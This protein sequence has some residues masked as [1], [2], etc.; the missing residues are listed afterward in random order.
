MGT[1]TFQVIYKGTVMGETTI[2]VQTAIDIYIDSQTGNR[3]KEIKPNT[4]NYRIIHSMDYADVLEEFSG[5]INSG[6]AIKKLQEMSQKVTIDDTFI[7]TL[8][9]K[10]QNNSRLSEYQVYIVLQRNWIDPI[11]APAIVTAEEDT[12]TKLYEREDGEIMMNIIYYK[13]KDGNGYNISPNGHLVIGQ[14]HGHNKTQEHNMINI[15]GT[16]NRDK[17]TAIANGFNIYSLRA[18]ETNV[19]GQAGIDKVDGK[20][21]PS[22]LLGSTRGRP[23]EPDK[24]PTFDVGRDALDFWTKNVK[25]WVR[26][27]K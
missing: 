2:K 26:P 17:K 12:H 10:T 27:K 3:F 25:V 13:G 6:E 5:N 15:E 14:V 23:N 18:Y 1:N 4:E 24:R 9:Q 22:L 19:G 21:V 8:M 11:E 20:G 16:S 7:Q